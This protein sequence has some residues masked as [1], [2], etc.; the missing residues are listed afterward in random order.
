MPPEHHKEIANFLKDKIGGN[1]SVAMYRD[2][3]D[4]RPIPIGEF[5]GK[6][7]ST[8]GAC[9]LQLDLPLGLFELASAGKNSWLPNVV[10]SSIYWLTGRKCTEWPLVCED[11]V[12]DN[13]K[14][15]YRHMSYIPSSFG[16]DISTGERVHW[17]LGVPISDNDINLSVGAIHDKAK[18]IFPEWL[19]EEATS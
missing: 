9:D 12:K 15:Q 13:S 16:L 6:F 8:I 19:F 18:S 4:A 1:A 17:L 10:A 14:S 5:D 7:F 11:V 2:N 3:N